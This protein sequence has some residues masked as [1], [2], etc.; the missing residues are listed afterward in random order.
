MAPEE[1]PCYVDPNVVDW[2]TPTDW[3]TFQYPDK[4]IKIATELLQMEEDERYL[5]TKL[6]QIQ[7]DLPDSVLE[8][9]PQ[10]YAQP[11]FAAG[12]PAAAAPAP[13]AEPPKPT[14]EIFKLVLTAL[15]DDA[16]IKVLK[17][18]R[19]LKPGM[20]LLEVCTDVACM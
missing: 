18:V 1:D 7:W 2:R 5:V 19:V 15:T 6:L 12:A 10:M 14:K 3:K 4:I 16:K 8:P 17:E 13:A 9:P 11:Q 20:K